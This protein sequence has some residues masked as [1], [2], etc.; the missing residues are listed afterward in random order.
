MKTP[1]PAQ[2]PILL[3]LAQ[4]LG[5]RAGGWGPL[6][7]SPSPAAGRGALPRVFALLLLLPTLLL[8]PAHTA[9]AQGPSPITAEVDRTTLTTDEALNLT[10]TVRTTTSEQVSPELP[11][12][13]GFDILGTST[14]QQLVFES[15]RLS[16]QMTYA[17]RLRP[18]QVGALSIPAIE[19]SI[20]GQRYETE[21][22]AIIATPGSGPVIPSA[23]PGRPGATAGDRAMFVEASVD[24]PEPYVGAPVVYTFRFYRDPRSGGLP[25]QPRYS[26]PA[27]TGF[28][29]KYAPDQSSATERIGDRIYE[30]AELKT[31]I[32]PTAP[33][34]VRIE[35]AKLSIPSGF[36]NAG[37]TLETEPVDLQVRPLPDGAPEGFD[38]A[39]GRFRIDAALDNDR[40][41]VGEPL[42]LTVSLRG[43]GN[44]D[45][46]PDP[47]WPELPAG[48]RDFEQR[49][50]LDSRAEGGRVDGEKRFE[51]LL[52]PG[53]PGSSTLPPIR[54]VFFDPDAGAYQTIETAPLEVAVMPGAASG[55][56]AAGAGGAGSGRGAEGSGGSADPSASAAIP[57]VLT[58]GQAGLLARP[59]AALMWLLWLLPLA[60]LAGDR[61]WTR[62]RRRRAAARAAAP[63]RAQAYASA[64]AKLDR[65]AKAG[66]EAPALAERALRDYLAARLERPAAGLSSEALAADLRARGIAPS[67]IERVTRCLATAEAARYAGAAGGGNASAALLGEVEAVIGEME[68]TWPG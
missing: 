49:A 23:E 30:V 26:A 1:T 56:A 65:A 64:R 42:G 60:L 7:Q 54:Y 29:N 58:Y 41:A 32:Y 8:A 63:A 14:S 11:S 45:A 3:P 53:Q 33:G 48:W 15:G 21:P 31:V 55:D 16:S 12:F 51:R 68:A 36:F 50:T 57:D 39:V 20:D 62:Q 13:D 43:E 52:I 46:L 4:P 27:F 2:A 59:P 44:L 66:P 5:E 40:A 35:P 9:L 61:L 25:R 19:V 10:I 22:I 28:W 17:F 47:R 34:P 37:A 24:N 18:N 6:P 38:G 67:L